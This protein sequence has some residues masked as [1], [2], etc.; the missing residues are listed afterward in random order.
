[1]SR[2]TLYRADVDSPRLARV[3]GKVPGVAVR[4][5]QTAEPQAESGDDETAAPDTWTESD[6]DGGL[7]EGVPD[8]DIVDE[9]ER[10]VVRSYGLLGL[11]VSMVV[12][13]VAT[14]GIWVY[15]RRNGDGEASETPPPSTGLD[16]AEPAPSTGLDTG[17][18]TP[19]TG[20]PAPSATDTDSTSSG[21]QSDEGDEDGTDDTPERSRTEGDRSDVE[22]TTRET[23]PAADDEGDEPSP[24]VTES[25]D[26]EDEPRATES[27]DAAPLLGVAFLAVS[28]AVVEWLQSADDS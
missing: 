8:T 28:G 15:L 18:T 23:T 22:W 16:T 1:M 7:L 13:G 12:L 11:G 19:S 17:E 26:D 2:F 24:D 14:V 25:A 21:V 10:S 4:G 9:D 5:E 6:E 20:T 3:L 27:V